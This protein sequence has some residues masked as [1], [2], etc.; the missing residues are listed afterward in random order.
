[1]LIALDL[2][3]KSHLSYPNS[4]STFLSAYPSFFLRGFSITGPS[5]TV[6]YHFS[7]FLPFEFGLASPA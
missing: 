4:S 5:N 2:F 1:M 6:D 3:P 7:S